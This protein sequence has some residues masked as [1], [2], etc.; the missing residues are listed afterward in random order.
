MISRLNDMAVQ[1][2]I[3]AM[4]DSAEI[5]VVGSDGDDE[6]EI[7]LIAS[8]LP[9]LDTQ[10]E[11]RALERDTAASSLL[12]LDTQEQ[13]SNLEIDAAA[14]DLVSWSRLATSKSEATQALV[15]MA[16]S[17]SPGATAPL[18]NPADSQGFGLLFKAID[19]VVP[20]GP[21]AQRT[22]QSLSLTKRTMKGG[23]GTDGYITIVMPRS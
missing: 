4:D 13:R 14:R 20:D 16:T 3:D 15:N 10:E 23:P 6:D 12:G 22:R 7:N 9:S 21:I 8:G 2:M 18:D 19:R 11:R 17:S 5:D 1:Q